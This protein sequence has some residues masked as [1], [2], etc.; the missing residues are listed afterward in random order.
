MNHNRSKFTS[1]NDLSGVN[2][3]RTLSSPV[4]ESTHLKGPNNRSGLFASPAKVVG[5]SAKRKPTSPLFNS[6]T[7]FKSSGNLSS[8][9]FSRIDPQVYTDAQSR[10]LV[11]RLVKYHDRTQSPLNRSQSMTSVY[12]KPGQFPVV[13]LKKTEIKY[14]PRRNNSVTSVRIAPPEKS[15]FQAN[16]RSNILRA[17]SLL[18]PAEPHLNRTRGP[19]PE[20]EIDAENRVIAPTAEL[21]AAPTKSVLDALKEISRKRINNEELDADRIKKQCKELSEVDSGG[22]GGTKRARELPSSASPPLKG[23]SEQLQKKRLCCKNNDILSSLSSS[24]VMS[25]PKRVEPIP[26]RPRGLNMDQTFATNVATPVGLNTTVAT[27]RMIESREPALLTRIESAPLPQIVRSVPEIVPA[28]R[29]K[30]TQPKIT[31]FNKKYDETLVRPVVSDNEEQDDDEELGGRIS[32]IKPK[33]KSPILNSDKA[34]LK[35]VEKSKL[36]LILSCLSEDNDDEEEPP[37]M[38]MNS[39]TV[40]KDTVDAP[41]PLPKVEEKKPEVTIPKPPSGIAA[42]ISE[43]IKDP[44]LGKIEPPKPS[45]PKASEPPKPAEGFSFGTPAKT[46]DLNATFNFQTPTKPVAAPVESKAPE[47][48]NGGFTFGTTA[49]VSTSSAPK[50]DA[51]PAYSFAT[52]NTNSAPAM[53]TPSGFGFGKSPPSSAAITTNTTTATPSLISF[54]P[55]PTSKNEPPKS[56]FSLLPAISTN[57]SSGSPQNTLSTAKSSI[58]AFGSGSGFSAFK[59][60]SPTASS[61]V[62]TTP[63]SAAVPSFG[64]ITASTPATTSPAATLS[65]T[66][67]F[68]FGTGTSLKLTTAISTATTTTSAFSFGA[69]TPV[70][71]T[72]ATVT[73]AAFGATSAAPKFGFGSTTSSTVPSFGAPT[74]TATTAAPSF[75]GFSAKAAPPT[76]A[77]PAFGSVVSS[78]NSTVT[79]PSAGIFGGSAAPAKPTTFGQVPSAANSTFS[80]GAQAQPA[81]STTTSNTGAFSF[82]GAATSAQTATTT[83]APVGATGSNI[84]GNASNSTAAPSFGAVPSFGTNPAPTF[85]ATSPPAFG[86]STTSAAPVAS[87][88]GAPPVFGG[89]SG[90]LA[91][92]ANTSSVFGG[93]S[94]VTSPFGATNST[95]AASTTNLFGAAS[96][97]NNQSNVTS[98]TPAP[99]SFGAAAGSTSTAAPANKP[100][101][102]GGIGTASTNNSNNSVLN[103]SVSSGNLAKASSFSFSAGSNS[104]A[105]APVAPQ[106]S[107]S[108]G[109][110]TNSSAAPPPAFGSSTGNTSF[111]FNANATN[112]TTTSNQAVVKPFSFGTPA[113][114]APA[115]SAAGAGIFGAAAASP[116]PAFNFSAGSNAA[117]STV[118]GATPAPAFSFTGGAAAAP[119]GPFAM[120]NGTAP[121]GAP[122]FSIGT[123]G[124]SNLPPGRRPIRTATRRLK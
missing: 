95:P 79:S 100:F 23:S 61:T 113:Q 73:P 101:A 5:G 112:N 94:S 39:H 31:L 77:P 15:V 32:F 81:A 108:F 116:P 28:V 118:G 78:S 109:N 58:P 75:G 56:G 57:A 16:T 49:A 43:P 13:H 26:S 71:P 98:S 46:T 92:S 19:Q 119:G 45:I 90:S 18:V 44:G 117:G 99:F 74:T 50:S 42:L 120:P 115:P 36:S 24:L 47:K 80:F 83:A 106:A 38:V 20:D 48:A 37:K 54:S 51:P 105:P 114:S 104:T 55:A 53:A 11:N 123:G 3:S 93:S 30:P 76:T 21:D 59:P 6:R 8:V 40:F 60:L 25:T 14:S 97:N 121:G 63:A 62:T 68:S 34:A 22:G 110:A 102:F 9:G 103:S 29:P 87:G 12:N 69:A 91:T 122:M 17:G 4:A 86:A 10:G 66:G 85:G 27:E 2:L 89:S 70:A 41:K 65:S 1:F 82:G 96:S 7:T 84:F 111:S 64:T 33:E 107:F 72:P 124:G 35:Q 88:F 67:G 52:A